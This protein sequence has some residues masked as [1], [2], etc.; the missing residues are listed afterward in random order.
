MPKSK[1]KTFRI[2]YNI[3][4]RVKETD[5]FDA[6]LKAL[7][8]SGTVKNVKFTI[9]HCRGGAV[10]ETERLIKVIESNVNLF[11]NITVTLGF[12]GYAVSAAAF[13][14]VYFTRYA[15]HPRVKVINYTPVCVVY[16]K[17]RLVHPRTKELGF[18]NNLSPV[19]N[20]SERVLIQRLDTLFDNVF[21]SLVSSFRAVAVEVDQHLIDSYN[22]NGD[23]AFTFS[24]GS[25]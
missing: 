9:S 10:N 22:S 6:Y 24:K 25:Q 21:D 1:D 7:G 3:S 8:K 23:A 20:I 14:F 11:P 4:E 2:A 19:F 15:L 5:D 18:A 16:H 13:L 12:S 17:P